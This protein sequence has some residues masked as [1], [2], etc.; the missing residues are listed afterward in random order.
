MSFN[1]LRLYKKLYYVL[2]FLIIVI[3]L[4]GEWSLWQSS[5]INKR[6]DNLYTQEI[7]P[8]E[9]ISHLKGALYRIRDRTLRLADSLTQDEI[10][11]H[12]EIINTQLLRIEQELDIY[13]NTRLSEEEREELQRFKTNLQEYLSIIRNTFYPL[14]E[15]KAPST[16]LNN[17]LHKKAIYEF[18]E[19]REALN[20]L[21]E[22]QIKRAKLRHK[23]SDEIFNQQIIIIQTIIILVIVIAVYLSKKLAS[24]ILIPI[25]K[26]NEALQR[27]SKSDYSK[28]IT[29]SSKDE[30]GD[31]IHMLNDNIKLL[32]STFKELDTLANYDPLTKLLNRRCFQKEL[33]NCSLEY[34][35]SN[36]MFAVMFIDLD[37]FKN[38][39]DTFG[40]NTGDEL[41][42]IISKRIKSQ[43][44]SSD[45]FA[46]LGGDEFAIIVKNIKTH[47]IP[48]NIAN[49]ILDIIQKPFYLNEHTIFTSVSIGIYISEVNKNLTSSEI[50]SFADLAMYE[51]KNSG[52]SQ[53]KY[54]NTSMHHKIQENS[55][56][57][58]SLRNAM[59][60]KEFE[61]FF[62]PIICPRDEILYGVEA[63]LR[64]K[65]D[66]TFISPMDFIPK[67]ESSGMIIDVTYF[68]IEDVFQT[69]S[70]ISY[71]S[72]VS[73]NLSILQFYD[74]NF[75]SFLRRMLHKYPKINPNLISFEITETV[76]AQNND[77]VL[78]TMNLIKHIGFQFSLDDF[79][80]GYSSLSY[81]KD[82]PI[83]ILKIDKKFVDNILYDPKSQKLLKAIILMSKSLDMTVIIEGVEDK[84]TLNIVTKDNIVKIQGYYYYRPLNKKDFFELFN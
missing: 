12:K 81:I 3:F 40:H 82:Y 5:Q 83:S 55:H 36:S 20:E 80:T 50:M 25:N 33:N 31:M 69:I 13:D 72:I 1:D 30:F 26:I 6:V 73:I 14:L 22:Y 39:N 32:Q 51:A 27:I 18:R 10:N 63:L 70:K 15:Q 35:T 44:K 17:I 56:L 46:R 68:I 34:T 8:L 24:S 42:L 58:N 75:I 67:L 9:N 53:Y 62:Q 54:F 79:G 47:A 28:G 71:K 49:K 29:F 77:A 43:L 45:I 11:K 4:M 64:W 41:L 57:E 19:A 23:H 7:I 60:N 65:K 74:E 59:K 48:G 84:K 21:S 38:I 61:I 37:N 76:F 66:D 78:S 52:K 16:M 2:G